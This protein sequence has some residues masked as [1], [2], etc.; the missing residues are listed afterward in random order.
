MWQQ[1]GFGDLALEMVGAM[2]IRFVRAFVEYRRAYNEAV[3]EAQETAQ[4]AG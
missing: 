4:K 1:E 2:G 3:R